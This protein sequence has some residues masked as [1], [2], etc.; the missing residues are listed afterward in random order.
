[1]KRLF[2]SIVAALAG[3][4]ALAQSTIQVEVHNIVELQERFNVVF[5]VEGEHAPSEFTWDAGEDFN[6][7]WG[8][9]RGTSTSVQII[10]GKTTRSSQT[11]YTYILQAKTTG[12]FTIQPA[13]AKVKGEVISSKPVSVQVVSGNTSS[14]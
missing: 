5:V 3:I 9:Q 4:A 14:Q 2:V 6:V 10:N 13:T 1:M 12:T 7:V 11:S 8:P